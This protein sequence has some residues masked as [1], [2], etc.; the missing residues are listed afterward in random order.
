[1]DRSITLEIKQ[2]YL[3]ATA[4]HQKGLL[5]EALQNYFSILRDQPNFADVYHNIAVIYSSVQKWPQA[6][7]YYLQAI[8]HN[9]KFSS[10]FAN[11][12]HCFVHQELYPQA[13]ENYQ[14]SLS[15]KSDQPHLHSDLATCTL[16]LG[17]TDQAQQHY[18]RALE[19]VPNDTNI[20]SR[21][22]ALQF[23]LNNFEA[24]R[25]LFQ[26]IVDI[27]SN[28]PA[29][30]FNLGK[31]LQ[32]LNLFKE[33]LAQYMKHIALNPKDPIG[34]N[35]LANSYA[36]LKD[37]KTAETHFLKL[38]K[39][40]P[41]YSDGQFNLSLLYLSQG[42]YENGWHFYQARIKL[43]PYPLP[44]E[45]ISPHWQGESLKD[46]TVI[47]VGEQ[48]IGDSIQCIRYV[49]N[50]KSLG[51]TIKVL[52]NK[53]LIPL[54]ERIPDIDA[55]HDLTGKV[56]KSDYHI[57]MFNLP[58]VFT[59]NL[60]SL[61]QYSSYLSSDPTRNDFWHNKFAHLKGLKVAI[62]WQGNPEFKSDRW[63]S[64]PLSCFTSL[65]AI[66]GVNLVSIQKGSAGTAQID[67]FLTSHTLFD[68]DRELNHDRDL[69]DTAA[70]IH[71]AD[72]VITSCTSIAH[73]A[74]ALGAPT[75]LLLNSHAD[76][77]WLNNRKD[78]PW[79]PSIQIYRQAQRGDWSFVFKQLETA[80]TQLS[81]T[82]LR[83]IAKQSKQQQ[84]QNIYQAATKQLEK[85]DYCK[86]LPRY[87]HALKLHSKDTSTQSL[88]QLHYDLATVLL[89]L[90]QLDQAKEHLL[91][92]IALNTDDYAAHY[93][94]AIIYAKTNETALA[95]KHFHIAI[96][97][98]SNNPA[99]Y[100]EL[101][102]LYTDQ[103]NAAQAQKYYH[104]ALKLQT[105]NLSKN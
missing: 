46:K 83:Q 16:A 52:C 76:W 104:Q 99:P 10:A 98:A 87:Q 44:P 12:G 82:R 96:D 34:Y 38:I 90:A 91:Q 62:C 54:F 36:L 40:F 37:Y 4:Q 84:F 100:F 3:Q 17:H 97:C 72:L 28:A 21:Y 14:K 6:Q 42:D 86:A 15:L 13:I 2:R 69:L 39:K 65:S 61:A 89:N 73:L 75:W 56:P 24:A 33:A 102:S 95:I 79:Y 11:L 26:K 31:T 55:V 71:C 7:Q 68:C 27:N 50:L 53:I 70:I 8:A 78:S 30:H 49:T 64:L 88:A 103:N 57:L 60:A 77:R 101:S 48:G 32:E 23:K 58:K 35:N 47:L 94:L 80:L 66:A 105:N 29:A 1:M 81:Q 43:A 45:S 22:A 41:K 59:P 67:E 93:N 18:L 9:P 20:I 5:N 92:V 51:A 25:L 74:G 85:G 19:L 63:R